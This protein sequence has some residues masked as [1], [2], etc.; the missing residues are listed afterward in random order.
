M[1]S[2]VQLI[3][4]LLKILKIYIHLMVT[5]YYAGLGY[6]PIWTYSVEGYSVVYIV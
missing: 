4:K 5:S 2:A 1:Q 6:I 3:G